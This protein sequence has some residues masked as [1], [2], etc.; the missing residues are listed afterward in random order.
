MGHGKKQKDYKVIILKIG[1]KD[2]GSVGHIISTDVS[3]G[4]RFYRYIFKNELRAFGP[5]AVLA[6]STARM[7]WPL[8]EMRNTMGRASLDIMC[9]LP[10]RSP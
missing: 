9:E 1:L 5:Q 3:G 6:L 2:I 10:I 4:D 8:M 7:E